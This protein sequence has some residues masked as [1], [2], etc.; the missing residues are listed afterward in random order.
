MTGTELGLSFKAQEDSNFD[1]YP[2]HVLPT[3]N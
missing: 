1:P 2:A 3:V